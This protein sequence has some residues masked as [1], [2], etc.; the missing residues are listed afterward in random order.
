VVCSKGTYIRSLARDIGAELGVGAH[1]TALRRTR[2]GSFHVDDSWTL[3]AFC[4]DV[5]TDAVQS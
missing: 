1:L 4:G 2:I 3:D 5:E